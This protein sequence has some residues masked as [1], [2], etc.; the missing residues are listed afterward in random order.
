[1]HLFPPATTLKSRGES[2]NR[3]L[4][5]PPAGVVI[6]GILDCL[7]MVPLDVRFPEPNQGLLLTH[8]CGDEGPNYHEMTTRGK[9]AY[10]V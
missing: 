1:M 8:Y 3:E 7:P 4:S 2:D 10:H 6:G 5:L 9:D